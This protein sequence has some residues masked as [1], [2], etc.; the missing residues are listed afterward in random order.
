M[1]TV[2]AAFNLG[3]KGNSQM[4]KQMSDEAENPVDG[5]TCEIKNGHDSI[6]PGGKRQPRDSSSDDFS[7]LLI[8]LLR[9]NPDELQAY[10][11]TVALN[12]Q[13]DGTDTYAHC[14]FIALDGNKRPR[15]N[16]F[17][18]CLASR[19]VDFAIPRQELKRAIDAAASSG[20]SEPIISLNNKAK[21]LFSRLPK[22]GEGGELLLSVL[23]E[24]YLRLPQLFT[25]MV[26]KTS[27][28]MHIHGSDGIHAGVAESGN[29]ALYWG[30]SKVF[31]NATEAVYKCF[32]SLAPFLLD[33]GGSESSQERDLCL[34][35]D[36]ISIDDLRLKEAIKKY[37]APDD[38]MFNKL[39]YRG[40]CL[41]GYNSE[42]Y[43]AKPNSKITEDLQIEIEQAFLKLQDH[44]KKR[45][46][47]EALETYCIHI[48]CLPFPCVDSFRTSFRKEVGL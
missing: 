21:A 29:L 5:T 23:A 26:L 4:G 15:V 16:D 41:V 6:L 27:T 2:L 44:I 22:S 40:L 42:A 33:N 34:L 39:E 45:V 14:H 8:P 7:A 37:L 20:S 1:Y 3:Y 10:L 32:R 46:N 9:R 38:P 12:V 17:A 13:V 24:A 30:E 43:P 19:I 35:R 28:E 25:K 11:T 18:K 36:G 48:F 31:R 47:K